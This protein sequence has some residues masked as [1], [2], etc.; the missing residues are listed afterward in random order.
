MLAIVILAAGKGSRTN[1]A[2]NKPL[3][4]LAD[5]PMLKW[6]YEKA[7]ALDPA[8]IIIV[9]PEDNNEFQKVIADNNV[10]FVKQITA[11]GTAAALAC[12]MPELN[13]QVTK[14]LVLCAD[15]PLV[16]QADLLQLKQEQC[17]SILT[18]LPKD[19]GSMGR[20]MRK[21]DGT[22]AAI[23]EASD[24]SVDE[25]AISEVFSGIMQSPRQLLESFLEQVDNNNAQAEYYLTQIIDYATATNQPVT[26]T[27]AMP[28]WQVQ[29]VNTLVELTDLER[30]YFEYKANLML[31]DGI[32]IIDPARFDYR[33]DLTCGQNVTIDINVVIKGE[34]KIGNNCYI[35]PSCILENVTIGD[36]T[37]VLANSVITD[38]KIANSSNI[39]P[40]AYIRPGCEIQNNCRIG[41]FVEIKNSRIGNNTKVPHLSYIGDSDFGSFV[42]VGAGV[43][44]CN[45]DG[46]AKHKTIV[47]DY[48]FIGAG[49]QLIA[50][51]KLEAAAVIGA[52]TCV[53]RDIKS[54]ALAVNRYE[55]TMVDNWQKGE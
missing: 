53:R 33:G 3:I 24:A 11:N 45:Y 31:A 8:Q 44:T 9:T 34:V 35:G 26:A 6:V 48:C 40:F 18:A 12:A 36:N 16:A 13:T 51:I 54:R 21:N 29:G 23:V 50:P 5:K 55:I 38:S 20:V 41:S 14:V 46:R 28:A 10:I 1:V 19:P 2:I 30:T 25:I 49:V 32:R 42:N 47:E 27:V 37:K 22:V 7:K 52:G 17:L 39:G 15:V 4:E 43:I